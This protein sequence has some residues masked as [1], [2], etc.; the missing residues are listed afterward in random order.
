MSSEYIKKIRTETGDKQIDYEALANLPDL[1]GY[2]K[3]SDLS[4]LQA[5]IDDMKQNGTGTGTGGGISS[6]FLSNL[7]TALDAVI[8]ESSKLSA[9]NSSMAYF[10]DMLAGGT[11]DETEVTITQSGTSL[12][13]SGVSDITTITQ[14]GTTLALA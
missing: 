9:F 3:Q 7:I 14:S 6:T 4:K 11:E 2:A 12:I 8:I 1:S 10:K 13:L 5:T